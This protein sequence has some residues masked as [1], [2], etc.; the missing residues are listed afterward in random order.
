MTTAAF[1]GCARLSPL[2][3]FLATACRL[4]GLAVITSA[5]VSLAPRLEAVQLLPGVYGYG[6]DRAVNSAGFGSNVAIVHVTNL[7]DLTSTGATVSGSLRHAVTKSIS[8]NPPRVVVFD[9][10]GAIKLTKN[11]TINK[12]N[13]T[14]A[15]QAAPG[16]VALEGAPLIVGA[17]NVLVQHLRLRPGDEWVSASNQ[18]VT[19][20]RDAAAV[21]DGM[22]N[23]AFDH[24]T[25]AWSLDEMVEGYYAY[26]NVTFHRC[27]FAEPLYIATHLDEGTFSQ[28]A[29]LNNPQQAEALSF[30]TSGLP[31][32]TPY[33]TVS[34]PT[35]AVDTHYHRVNA[36]S[37]ND[38]I[39]YTISIPSSS[40]LRN[41]EHILI[42]GIKGPDRG[43][44]RVEVRLGSNTTPVQTSEEFD[45][46]APTET[47]AT[48]VSRN[49]TPFEFSL[50]TAATT[51]KVK[52][53]VTD[54][55]SASSGFK[56]GVD[57]IS[58][59]Q[60]HGMGPYFRDGNN[61]RSPGGSLPPLDLDG[62]LSIIGS[63]FAHLQARGPWVASKNLVLANNVF[64]N[65]SQE[66]VMLGV[67]TSY[68]SMKAYIVGNTFMEGR[69]W[70][71][72][73]TSPVRNTQ[74]P[75]GSQIRLVDNVYNHGVLAADPAPNTAPALYNGTNHTSNTTSTD[76]G[77][78]GFSPQSA[79][80]AYASALLNAGAWPSQRDDI[81]WRV[82]NDIAASAN[83]NDFRLRQGELKNTIAETGGWPSIT[84]VTAVWSEPAN[85]GGS[86][87]DYTNL[88]VRLHQLAAQVE[89]T[90]SSPPTSGA[91]QAETGT[92]AG[93]AVLETTVAG[94]AGTGYVNF[95]VGSTGTPSTLTFSNVAGGTGGTRV[96]RIRHGLGGTTS[97]TGTL[98][99]NGVA[100]AITFEPTGAF[101]T[102]L[103]KD[104][105]IALNSGTSN[106][107]AFAAT[108]QDLA[109]IDEIVVFTPSIHQAE[110]ATLG[111][112]AMT[113]TI[114]TG[115]HGTGYVN[116]LTGSSGT[117][118]TATFGSVPGGSGGAK[119]LLIRYAFNSTSTRTGELAINSA[120]QP[121]T[122]SSTGSF[123]TWE[124]R[125]FPI[126]LN[127]GSNTIAL[128][129][130]GQDLANVDEI[131]VY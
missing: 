49:G 22:T 4:L 89:G 69:N 74:L 91:I 48:F 43:K 81:E 94:Y 95:A 115:Y 10:S 68:A 7:D 58:L 67:S 80:D 54:Q 24:C 119:T 113:E 31:G 13:V 29:S 3:V 116:F 20:N 60:P 129:A 27:I 46:Y 77:M 1:A 55:N 130:T 101:T 114:N 124:T 12:A 5:L 41:E 71:T 21:S 66:F 106:T 61:H 75:S 57:Q 40:S 90:T 118:S 28:T 85:P 99:I 72:F 59:T 100:Q 8:G 11:L 121:I 97:R 98:T 26:D 47:P 52:L 108:G 104:V 102:W 86:A 79:A 110:T 88:E 131:F 6:T 53:I 64:Y 30:T 125:T 56:L 76:D 35:L 112:G 105:V 34:N 44:F 84:P 37:V 39:E 45:M 19:F 65:R 111:G 127:S 63:I 73:T 42:S 36:N 128:K 25:F 92:R 2:R 62:K 87:G 96:L 38:S 15:G 33:E 82:I 93:S 9:V 51:M 109:N 17:S 120:S 83:I 117:P 126:S 18:N 50:G 23:I 14:I 103:N 123:T 78:S 16:P 32:T 122:F 70:E 107:I